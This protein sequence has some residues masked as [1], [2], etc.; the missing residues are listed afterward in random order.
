MPLEGNGGHANLVGGA[1]CKKKRTPCPDQGIDAERTTRGK[2][3]HPL[4]AKTPKSPKQEILGGVVQ[5]Y[6]E[7]E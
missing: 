3:V 4:L 6:D 5:R 1:G 7:N 2:K